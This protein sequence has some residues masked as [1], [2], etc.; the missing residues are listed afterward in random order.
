[1]PAPTDPRTYD[2]TILI[3]MLAAMLVSTTVYSLLSKVVNNYRDEILLGVKN[4]M[5]LSVKHRWQILTGDWAPLEALIVGGV[6]FVGF[7][8]LKLARLA[9]DETIVWIG[10]FGAALH[11]WAVLLLVI[12]IPLDAAMLVRHLRAQRPVLKRSNPTSE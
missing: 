4:G 3:T 9:E 6:S 8:Y 7:T 12:F 1:M 2:L 10:Y 11:L 5:P